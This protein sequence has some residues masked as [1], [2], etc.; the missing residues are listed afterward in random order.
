MFCDQ[1]QL[2]VSMI[3]PGWMWGPGDAGPTS[4]GKLFLAVARGALRAVPQAGNHLVDARDVAHACV[5]AIS[6]GDGAYIVAGSMTPLPDV[7]AE[8]ASATWAPA[9]GPCPRGLPCMSPRS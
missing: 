4:S 8:V 3:R 2:R 6:A 1:H 9:R 5:R 7:C